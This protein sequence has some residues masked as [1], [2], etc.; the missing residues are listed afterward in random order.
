[1]NTVPLQGHTTFTSF[2][3]TSVAGHL[4]SLQI[5]PIMD[6]AVVIMRCPVYTGHVFLFLLGPYL[7]AELLGHRV[8][9]MFYFQGAATQFSQ[10]AASLYC[11]RTHFK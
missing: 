11:F 5:L 4:D 1:M 8:N 3:R 6:Q 9:P 2:L 10:A 7:R